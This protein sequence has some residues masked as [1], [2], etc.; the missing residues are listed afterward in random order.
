MILNGVLD[1]RLF[2][3]YSG[4]SHVVEWRQELKRALLIRRKFKSDWS[5]ESVELD[6]EMHEGII[7]RGML[8]GVKWQWMIFHEYNCFL[9][10]HSEH[11]PNPPSKE[12]CIQ[13]SF[14][15]Y[16]EENVRNW[17]YSLPFKSIPFRL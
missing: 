4:K 14:E 6:C 15:L 8:S 1:P 9:L 13:R 11:Q 3:Q 17:W 2:P 10:K 7:T 5:G 12:W 16:G